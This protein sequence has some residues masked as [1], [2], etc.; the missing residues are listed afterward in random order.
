[1]PDDDPSPRPDDAAA[2]SALDQM[3][4][5]MLDSIAQ[6]VVGLD[7]T[8]H[9]IYWNAAAVTCFGWTTVEAMG[10]DIE[11]LVAQQF[12]A[13]DAQQIFEVLLAGRTWTGERRLVR[14]DGS[15]FP[16]MMAQNGVFTDAGELIGLIG[17]VTDLTELHEHEQARA[18]AEAEMQRSEAERLAAAVQE[19]SREERW[20]AMVSLSA[21]GALFVDPETLEITFASP[22]MARLFGWCPE[23]VLGRYAPDLVHP[24]D[25]P[26]MLRGMRALRST[27]DAHPTAEFRLACADGS[28]RW[29]EATVS[30][31][32]SGGSAVGFVGNLRD[33]TDRV[34]AVRALK[35]SEAR[36]RMIAETAQE[37]IVTVDPDGRVVFANQKMAD[38]LGLPLSELCERTFLDLNPPD[39]HAEILQRRRELPELG[40]TCYDFPFRRGDGERRVL[41]VSA[42]ALYDET[43]FIGTLSMVSDVTEAL[44]AEADLEYRVFHDPLTGLGNRALLVQKLGEGRDTADA[45]P[46]AVLLADIDQFKL[47]NDSMGHASGDELLIAVA[48]R[49]SQ[50]LRPGDLLARIGGDEF[51]VLCPDCTEY[52]A[53]LIADRLQ[54]ALHQPVII[55]GRP[56]AVGA[57]IGV[58]V[59]QPADDRTAD[60][61]LGHADAAMYEAKR[62]GRGRIATFTRDLVDRAETRLRLINDL[63][64]AIEEGR[65]RLH[66]QPIIE[67]SSGRLQGVEA[68]CRWHHE[69]HGDIPPDEFIAVAEESGLITSLDRWVLRRACH[70]AAALRAAGVL[71][72]GT[73]VTVNSSAHDLGQPDYE[74]NVR[75]VLDE[76]GL[77]AE[78]LVLEV[79]ESAVMRDPDAA[80]TVFRRLREFGVRVAIDDFGTGHSS[81]AYLR[82]YPV[83]M[84]KVDR[85]FVSGVTTS[86][87]DLAIV[88]T[89]VDLAHAIGV[90]TV[91]EGIETDAE[92]ALL[93]SIGCQGG[94]G[95]LWSRALPL[96]E[97]VELVRGMP[98][99][100][101]IAPRPGQQYAGARSAGASALA[102][103]V[104]P[105]DPPHAEKRSR[106]DV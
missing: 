59:R 1:M 75:T 64:I 39:R 100:F 81:L 41:R 95:W 85:S 74:R 10:R 89:I 22:P 70:D 52:D 3:S 45:G 65:L 103:T 15:S 48:R 106:T 94:Q 61:L 99:G 56:V 80:Q 40:N 66:Y 25:M 13:D 27:A 68:L 9:V 26:A 23:T 55:A 53:A 16:A 72:D 47:V 37:G 78:A 49:W 58:A 12:T 76:A 30:R 4:R 19:S 42:S 17:V 63:K 14:R 84:L 29:V 57:S 101:R 67:L 2:F 28:Y 73:Y 24:D 44:A 62:R 93:T 82:H 87:S 90:S 21:D 77:P 104:V 20:R 5:L 91:C 97:L 32:T 18:L 88:S 34:E 71:P 79:T 86:S 8:G 46:V 92:L 7:P 38:L 31:L 96:D 33:I 6:A 83:A 51:V 35:A 43:G 54:A 98:G 105:R 50:V 36:Y 69:E 60:M 102:M 11:E